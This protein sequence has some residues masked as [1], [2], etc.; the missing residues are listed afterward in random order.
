MDIRA[1]RIEAYRPALAGRAILA[2]RAVLAGVA[3]V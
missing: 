2:G 1:Q 3:G